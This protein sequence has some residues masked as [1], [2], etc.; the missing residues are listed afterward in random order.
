MVLAMDQDKYNEAVA[1]KEAGVSIPAIAHELEVSAQTIRNWFKAQGQDPPD[2][3]KSPK[4]ISIAEAYEEG[5]PIPQILA[6]FEIGR[7]QLYNILSKYSVPTRQVILE[8]T[9]KRAMDEACAMYEQG[10]VIRQI[11]EDTGIHQPT[12]HAELARR[13]IPLRRPRGQKT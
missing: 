13:G 5:M 10:F 3:L 7:P 1:M 8:N 6:K 12:L 2:A 11:T 4:D 9:R